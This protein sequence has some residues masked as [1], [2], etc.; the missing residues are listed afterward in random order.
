MPFSDNLSQI[1]KEKKLTQQE[2]AR[3][4]G[5]GIAQVRRYEKG[6]SSPTLEAIKKLSMSLGISADELIFDNN[7]QIASGKILD[8]E[9]LE[10]FEMISHMNLHDINAIKTILDGMIMKNKLK[11]IMPSRDK[12]WENEIN[13]VIDKFR[14]SAKDYSKEEVDDLINEAVVAVRS[15]QSKTGGQKVEA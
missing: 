10:Q 8:K 14:T 3:L 1:R 6:S 12:D 15:D 7:T 9:L 11:S 13:T 4:A 5:V 2:V